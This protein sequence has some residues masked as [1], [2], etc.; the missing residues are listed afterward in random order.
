MQCWPVGKAVGNVRNQGPELTERVADRA[1]SLCG[2]RGGDN[3]VI[4]ENEAFF[5]RDTKARD[6]FEKAYAET[7]S[8]YYR[9]RPTFSEILAVTGANAERL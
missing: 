4:A 2:F 6:A 8:P 5:L 1:E 7:Q 9:D 3:P